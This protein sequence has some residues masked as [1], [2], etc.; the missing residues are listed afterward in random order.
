MGQWAREAVN[1]CL[2]IALPQLSNL[3]L[4][5][6]QVLP[7][8]LVHLKRVP[9]AGSSLRLQGPIVRSHSVPQ[10]CGCSQRLRQPGIPALHQIQPAAIK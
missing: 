6:G 9:V 8:V 1:T 5:L 10:L 7:Q 2:S 4:A 3:A